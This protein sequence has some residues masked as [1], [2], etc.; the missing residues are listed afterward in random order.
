VSEFRIGYY[1][2]L[3]PAMLHWSREEWEQQIREAS[4]QEMALWLQNLQEDCLRVKEGVGILPWPNDESLEFVKRLSEGICRDKIASGE[5]LSREQIEVLEMMELDRNMIFKTIP[6]NRLAAIRTWKYPFD[7][8]DP[9][10]KDLDFTI[11]DAILQVTNDFITRAHNWFGVGEWNIANRHYSNALIAALASNNL[12]VVEM[13]IRFL[14]DTYTAAGDCWS[15]SSL[16]DDFSHSAYT[17]LARRITKFRNRNDTYESVVA[18]FALRSRWED[19]QLWLERIRSELDRQPNRDI[20]QWLIVQLLSDVYVYRQDPSALDHLKAASARISAAIDSPRQ[21]VG[22]AKRDT[23]EAEELSQY[24]SQLFKSGRFAK[25]IEVWERIIKKHRDV[26]G[27]Q[28]IGDIFTALGNTYLQVDDHSSALTAFRQATQAW[29]DNVLAW[30]GMGWCHYLNT[31]FASAIAA[32]RRAW[33]LDRTFW[34]ARYFLIESLYWAKGYS[35]AVRLL[36]DFVQDM[37]KLVLR[38][39]LGRVCR[40]HP[41]PHVV[42]AACEMLDGNYF[43]A[44][45]A[46]TDALQI[47]PNYEDANILR[48]TMYEMRKTGNIRVAIDFPFIWRP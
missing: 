14:T 37:H 35:D 17:E 30:H 12:P 38:D 47:D 43:G 25:A 8:I 21:Q 33:D 24:A 42:L 20:S 41:R 10:L 13:I 45:F 23:G 18:A 4:E 22:S 15:A 46:L 34:L 27:Q 36:E 19:V 1:R 39:S 26:L 40:P 2:D 44:N 7:A 16:A 31:E 29:P 32:F 11:P 48:S 3:Y 9:T 6:Q 5:Q 28:T